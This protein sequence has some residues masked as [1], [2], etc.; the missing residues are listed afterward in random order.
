MPLALCALLLLALDSAFGNPHSA[1]EWA[2][3]F[4]D[5]TKAFMIM[6]TK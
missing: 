2:N 5:D 3:F 1:L 4:M 6:S